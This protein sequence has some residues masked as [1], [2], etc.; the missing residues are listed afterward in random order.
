MVTEREKRS[1]KVIFTNAVNEAIYPIQRQS[2]LSFTMMPPSS[3]KLAVSSMSSWVPLNFAT[4]STKLAVNLMSPRCR[5]NF[6]F[7]AVS[8]NPGDQFLNFRGTRS[9]TPAGSTVCCWPHEVEG[10]SIN[11]PGQR[12]LYATC[13]STASFQQHPN[14]IAPFTPRARPP[15]MTPLPHGES[16]SKEIAMTLKRSPTHWRMP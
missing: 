12:Q 4:M 10:P 1:L 9:Q 2:L 13:T 11:A 5:L 7:A 8:T 15:P 14:P 16:Q 3:M 6:R